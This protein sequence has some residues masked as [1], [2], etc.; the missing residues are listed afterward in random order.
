MLVGRD[1][2][3]EGHQLVDVDD[4]DGLA[5]VA[6]LEIGAPREPGRLHLVRELI[7]ELDLLGLPG[8]DL[9]GLVLGA[10]GDDEGRRGL[11]VVTTLP[12]V[13]PGHKVANCPIV[14]CYLFVASRT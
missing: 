13:V 10:A 12:K 7:V 1:L 9:L 14:L 5:G 2:E 8:A 4:L 6:G 11:R 3:E